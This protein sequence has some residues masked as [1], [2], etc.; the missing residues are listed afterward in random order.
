M[1]LPIGDYRH[2]ELPESQAARISTVRTLA[3][4][5]HDNAS[6]GYLVEVSFRVP[7]HLHDKLDYAPVAKRTVE[8]HELSPYQ[9]TIAEKFGATTGTEKLVPDLGVHRKVLYHIGLLKFWLE[10]GVEIFEVH[11][12]WSWRQSTWMAEYITGMARQRATS[13]DPVL[14]EV[15]K[16]AMNSLYGK[17]LQDKS[18]QRNLRPFTSAVAFVKACGRENFVDSHIM[19]LD[20]RPGVPFFGLVETRKARGI[21]LDSP[22]A[23]GF[24]ILEQSK[25]HMLR[26]HYNFFK[27][28]Y[29]D[30]ATPLFTDTDSYCYHI[31]APNP[32]EDMLR[33]KEVLFDLL[34]A[35][36]ECDLAALASCPAELESLKAQLASHEL[37]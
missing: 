32:L 8:P 17:M 13:K 2:E 22:R 5:Y 28:T 26:A 25:L 35:F 31:V 20:D 21:I 9:R 1:P 30:R 33:S 6:K 27:P 10:M 12:L 7:Y 34:T 3:D 36:E 24:T 23:A 15:I 14:R 19:Q 16:K 18:S 11:S 4:L 29:G 37:H